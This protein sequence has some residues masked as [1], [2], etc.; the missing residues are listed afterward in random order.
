MAYS[1]KVIDH[2]EKPR[3]VGS[4]DKNDPNVGTGLVGAPSCGDLMKLQIK[5]NPE[6]EIIQEAKFKTFGCLAGN[7]EIATPNGYKKISSLKSGDKVWAWNGE[8]IVENIIKDNIKSFVHYDEL[9]VL[10]FA[11]SHKIICT[12]DHIW[13]AADNRPIQA[14]DLLS[15]MELLSATKNEFSS[16]NNVGRQDWLRNKNSKHMIEFNKIFDHSTL[17]QNNK[18]FKHSLEFSKKISVASKLLWQKPEYVEKWQNSMVN[19]SKVRPTALEKDF[20]KLFEQHNMEV[21]YVGN[22]SFWVNCLDGSKMN[23]DFKVNGQRKLIEVYTKKL[24]HFMQNRETADWMVSKKQKYASKNFDCMFI[25]H[26]ELNS[27]INEVNR[28]VHNGISLINSK[29]ITHKNELRGLERDKD[30]V[31]VFDLQLHEGANIFFV[32]RVMSHN[33]GSAIASSSLATEWIMGKTIDQA[34]Q[35]SNIIIVEELN[36]PPIK[37]HCSLLAEDAIKAAIA[38]YRQKKAL[39]Q[40]SEIKLPIVT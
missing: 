38:D 20:I 7:N 26:N 18:G 6:N 14:Q 8:Q 5:V 22:G 35:V 33:C 40:T 34:T 24:P 27:C 32:Q 31:A 10:D 28:F 37:T 3:N 19:A 23:P 30:E 36:L 39:R 1:E 25:E 21:R 15:G 9:L 2:F 29:T 13:W 16:M 4:L 11:L 17:P 12:K